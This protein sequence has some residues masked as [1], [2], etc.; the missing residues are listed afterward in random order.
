MTYENAEDEARG[1]GGG[2][3]TNLIE[4]K[5]AHKKTLENLYEKITP[6]CNDL[7]SV[8]CPHGVGGRFDS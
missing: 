5:V 8:P 6:L 4:H 1:A 7:R 2:I 3:L